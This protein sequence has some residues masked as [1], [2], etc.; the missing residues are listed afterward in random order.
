MLDV[1]LRYTP[2]FR[3]RYFFFFSLYCTQYLAQQPTPISSLFL[4]PH[5]YVDDTQL[6]FSSLFE[7]CSLSGRPA[8]LI[9]SCMSAN[10]CQ[11]LLVMFPAV[12]V[13]NRSTAI[14]DYWSD[15]L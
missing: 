9:S 5:V 8:Q 1:F 15:F 13:L 11:I 6:F 7:R 2:L 10:L 3:V 4:N 12:F 14:A